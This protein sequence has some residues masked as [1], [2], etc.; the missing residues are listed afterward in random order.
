[1]ILSNFG[2]GMKHGLDPSDEK[3]KD[4]YYFI[5]IPNLLTKL[6]GIV[7][8]E[9]SDFPAK[10]KDGVDPGS[11]D[12]L[13]PENLIQ[14]REFLGNPPELKPGDT[15]K[16]DSTLFQVNDENS[17]IPVTS[18]TGFGG[19]ERFKEMLILEFDAKYNTITADSIDV[20]DLGIPLS[21]LELTEI[22]TPIQVPKLFWDKYKI[23]PGK[24]SVKVIVK[25]VDKD[26][27]ELEI[28]IIS[29]MSRFYFDSEFGSECV[30]KMA[31]RQIIQSCL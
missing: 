19:A 31:V 28:E 6:N 14:N 18:E 10:L 9:S 11:E 29:T 21:D 5:E 30:A 3:L 26:G 27:D 2:R 15:F 7:D 20:E 12:A 23:D 8:W 4:R 22:D 17:I 24:Q 1:M 16:W 25:S 13:K